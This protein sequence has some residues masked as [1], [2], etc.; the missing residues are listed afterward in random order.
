M[1]RLRIAEIFESVQGEGRRAGTPSVFIR[2]S[3]CNMRCVWCDTPYASWN[4]E[5]PVIE[6][7]DILAQVRNLSAEHVV[8]TGGEPMMFSATVDLC[9][10]LRSMGR[11]ITVETA[12]TVYR[13]LKCDLMSVSPKLSNSTPPIESGWAK[14]HEETRLNF[15]VLNQLIANYDYQ[16]KFVV[17]DSVEG[18]IDEIKTILSSL[19]DI[20][21]KR[22][23]LMPEGVEAEVIRTRTDQLRPIALEHGWSVTPR[24][25]IEMFGNARGT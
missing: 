19:M 23:L 4:P 3:G 15:K 7:G 13:E 1:S 8:V 17:G 22:V 12:G 10:G 18:D 24:L 6:V 14:I 5:G 16:L 2:V 20:D 25:H 11:T 9:Q 21:P